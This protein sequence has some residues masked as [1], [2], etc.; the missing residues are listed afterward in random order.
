MLSDEER[1]E[2]KNYTN[3]ASFKDMAFQQYRMEKIKTINKEEVAFH[4]QSRLTWIRQ[5]VKE[6][7][8]PSCFQSNEK[9]MS[10]NEHKCWKK[11][12]GW[13]WRNGFFSSNMLDRFTSALK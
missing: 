4:H 2:E 10:I 7:Y 3:L 12:V 5:L 1:N 6:R 8:L 11:H 13:L 9:E